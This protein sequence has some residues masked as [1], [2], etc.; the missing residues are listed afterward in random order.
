MKN[1]NLKDAE[2]GVFLRIISNFSS[3]SLSVLSYNSSIVKGLKC[4]GEINER[5]CQLK[6]ER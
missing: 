1:C 6:K 4:K 5:I 2:F 3:S